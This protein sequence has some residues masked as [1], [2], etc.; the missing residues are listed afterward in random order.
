MIR[1]RAFTNGKKE[2]TDKQPYRFQHPSTGI[3][4][5]WDEW[6]SA[7]DPIVIE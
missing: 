3:P 2:G 4:D 5:V 6:T 7:L 1:H